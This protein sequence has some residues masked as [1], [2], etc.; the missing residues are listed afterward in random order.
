MQILGIEVH[1][2]NTSSHHPFIIRTAPLSTSFIDKLCIPGS[3]VYP[4]AP[5]AMQKN[6]A[7]KA[8]WVQKSSCP[9]ADEIFENAAV[10]VLINAA[11]QSMG[12]ICLLLL[13]VH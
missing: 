9:V 13:F 12:L 11:R 10:K 6:Q 7:K 8:S 4:P 5:H 2:Q 1:E 3:N